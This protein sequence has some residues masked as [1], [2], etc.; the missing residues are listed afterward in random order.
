MVLAAPY[1]AARYCQRGRQFVTMNYGYI[2][3]FNINLYS[4]DALLNI[5]FLTLS[6]R[7]HNQSNML[8]QIL[9]ISY[10]NETASKEY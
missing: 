9:V 5:V 3:N 10:C 4:F 8:H 2:D 1:V 6:L 7:Y